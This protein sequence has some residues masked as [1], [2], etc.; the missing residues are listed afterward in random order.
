VVADE[1]VTDARDGGHRDSSTLA[2]YGIAFL[3]LCVNLSN[4]RPQL[5]PL[6]AREYEASPNV[7]T[8]GGLLGCQDAPDGAAVALAFLWI[9][10]WRHGIRTVP[11]KLMTLD[12]I[13]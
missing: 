9:V 8:S 11:L 10:M 2:E 1:G 4:A 7:R 6:C 5:T 3:L 12:P 13:H